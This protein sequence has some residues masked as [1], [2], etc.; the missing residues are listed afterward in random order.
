MGP[1]VTEK[2][3]V[4][5]PAEIR[6]KYGLR[7]GSRV[8]FVETDEGILIVPIVPLESLYGVDGVEK[9]KVYGII[10]ELQEERRKEA[11]GES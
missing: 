9:E 11:A 2:G 10:K 1:V 5:I 8:E 6:R 4:T 3:T 7:K